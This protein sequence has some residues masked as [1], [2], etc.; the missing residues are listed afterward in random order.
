M[1]AGWPRLA[2]LGF[3]CWE[4]RVARTYCKGLSL[5]LAFVATGKVLAFHGT[6][7]ENMHSI[8]HLGLKN[9]SGTRLERTGG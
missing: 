6:H 2:T 5:Q 9:A 3:A 8:L 1:D 7:M 4:A